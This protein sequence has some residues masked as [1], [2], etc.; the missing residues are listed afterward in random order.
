MGIIVNIAIL[1][2]LLVFLYFLKKKNVKFSNR[3]FIA[4]AIGVVFGAVLQWI[5]GFGSE[6]ITKTMPWFNIIGNG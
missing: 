1:I 3:V 5:Y 6:T 4:L 2:G